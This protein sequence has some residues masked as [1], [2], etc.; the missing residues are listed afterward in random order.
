MK[1]LILALAVFVAHSGWAQSPAFE[2]A[3]VRQSNHAANG[4][5]VHVE[6]APGSLTIRGVSLR[7]CIEWAYS[8]PPFQVDAPAW[9]SDDGFD[10][11]A[12]ASAPVDDVQLRLMLRTLLTERFGLKVHTTR[13]ELP[14]YA[15]TLA[16]GGP[17][18]KTSTTEG[19]PSFGNDGRA[20]M[21]AKRVSMSEFASKISEPLGRPVVDATGLKGR[22]DIQINV[23]SYMSEP[24]AKGG[25]LD[26]MSLLFTALQ[27]QLGVKLVSR[28]DTVDVLVVDHAEKLPA[29]N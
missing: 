27:K 22:Y 29:E 21:T 10:I 6:S 5:E 16:P 25:E 7:F 19:S 18:F 17:K 23:T 2:A 12:K 4:D 3:S 14:V 13:K 24:P 26:V 11:V 20:N 28:K 15:L 9:L 1:F 8:V